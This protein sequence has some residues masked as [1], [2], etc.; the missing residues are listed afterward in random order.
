L[1]VRYRIRHLLVLTVL[2]A[3]PLGIFAPELRS[4]DEHAQLF[5]TCGVI[6]VLVFV[7]FTPLWIIMLR[8]RRRSH[9]GLKVTRPD[10]ATIIA[11]YALC[12]GLLAGLGL[13]ASWLTS[14]R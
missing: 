11:T 9:R 3:I 7:A 4:W 8:I 1:A 13:A 10:V 12:L 2:L 5:G 14:G 6:T